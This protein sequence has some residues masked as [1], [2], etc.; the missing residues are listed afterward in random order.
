L[1]AITLEKKKVTVSTLLRWWIQ[2]ALVTPQHNQHQ[3][4][5]YTAC[6]AHPSKQNQPKTQP[7]QALHRKHVSRWLGVLS[8]LLRMQQPTNRTKASQCCKLATNRT[9]ALIYHAAQQN[10]TPCN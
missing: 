6:D 9:S 10:N 5:D 8:V 1:T 2:G 3:P 7:Q 4:S